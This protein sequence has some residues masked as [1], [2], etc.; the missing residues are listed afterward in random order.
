MRSYELFEGGSWPGSKKSIVQSMN[1]KNFYGA[2]KNP[3]SIESKIVKNGSISGRQIYRGF[4]GLNKIGVYYIDPS[5]A[6]VRKSANTDNYY[7]WWIDHVSKKWKDYPKRSQSFIC[8]S[9]PDIAGGYGEVFQLI[10]IKSTTIGICPDDDFWSSFKEYCPDGLNRN[11]NEILEALGLNL[12]LTS[13]EKFIQTLKSMNTML[14]DKKNIIRL[15]NNLYH[16]S[17]F[18]LILK[19]N[20]FDIFKAMDYIYDPIK[21]K[22]RTMKWPNIKLPKYN[23]I[24]FS[25]PCYAI[26][27]DIMD[28]LRFGN[29]NES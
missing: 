9:N 6:P 1:L 11:L 14:L 8:G 24:W 7:T 16:H 10:P 22:F 28:K 27:K 19:K 26:H 21:F 2:L 23:E 18:Y 12:D 29:D 4:S 5:T 3:K 13:K 17:D 25:F 15:N 20:Q